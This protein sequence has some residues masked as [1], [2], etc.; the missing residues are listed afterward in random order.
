M[1]I[2]SSSNVD[3]GSG[4]SHPPTSSEG[5]LLQP[6]IAVGMPSFPHR[7]Q[8]D[9]VAPS[10]KHTSSAENTADAVREAITRTLPAGSNLKTTA[11]AYSTSALAG[12]THQQVVVGRVATAPGIVKSVS[13]GAVNSLQSGGGAPPP[14]AIVKSQ[15]MVS[16]PTRQKVARISW[17]PVEDRIIMSEVQKRGFRWTQIAN[18]LH[19]RTDDA[20][21]NRWHRIQKHAAVHNM[22]QQNT[23]SA[24]DSSNVSNSNSSPTPINVALL[25]KEKL[26]IAG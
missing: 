19:N 10:S 17:T 5:S 24:N 7:V 11:A 16:A 12:T 20:V 14:P 3:A 2:T 18:Q 21:R 4:E 1:P 25:H 9:G 13:H 22:T 8:P 15:S 26:S 6:A 23:G